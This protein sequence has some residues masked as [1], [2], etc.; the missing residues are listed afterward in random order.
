MEQQSDDNLDELFQRAAEEYPLKTDNRNWD[1]VAAK[2]HTS[3]TVLQ[4][5]KSK[6]WQYSALLLLLL[7]GSFLLINSLNKRDSAVAVNHQSP[8]SE[9]NKDKSKQQNQDKNAIQPSPSITNKN[10]D[11]AQVTNITK[12]DIGL[13]TTNTISKNKASLNSKLINKQTNNFLDQIQPGLQP[14]L[15]AYNLNNTISQLKFQKDNIPFIT[16]QSITN[17]AGKT[18]RQNTNIAN[19]TGTN[20][21]KSKHVSLQPQPKTFYGMF[22]FSPDFS[23][24]KFQHINKPGFSIG[25]GLGYRINNRFSAEIGLQRVHANFYSDG[26]YFDTSNIKMYQSRKLDALNGNNKLTEVPVALKYNLLKAII[27]CTPTLPWKQSIPTRRAAL[28][29]PLPARANPADLSRTRTKGVRLTRDHLV[30]Y[31]PDC[32]CR[33]QGAERSD[34]APIARH[35]ARQGRTDVSPSSNRGSA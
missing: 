30:T 35:P 22:F 34:A 15:T 14:K 1:I 12:T 32:G 8:S 25:I 21:R 13:Q 26:K 5:R 3:P 19:N 2:L 29:A 28:V 9:K 11:L 20:N 16:N 18:T 6:K 23:T 4:T 7:G 33:L 27:I 31:R 24:I 10:N 17:Q